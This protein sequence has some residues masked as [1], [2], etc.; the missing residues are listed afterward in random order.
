MPDW[1]NDPAVRI[2]RLLASADRRLRESFL[3]VVSY[4][5]DQQS[6]V[7]IESLLL[8]GQLELAIER[9]GAAFA[10]F[11][12]DYVGVMVTTAAN[13]A[14]LLGDA[15]GVLVSFDQ[16]HFR[17]VSA[18]QSNRLRLIREF[19]ATQRDAT[20][21]SLIDTISRGLGPRQQALAFRSSIGLTA[22][23]EAAVQNFRRMLVEGDKALFT[24]ALRDRRFDPTIRNALASGKPLTG[25]QVE[26]MVGRYRER[27]IKHRTEV[28]ARTES[29]RSVHQADQL[30]YQQAIDEGTLNPGDVEQFWNTANDER[31]RDTHGPMHGQ[32][33][34]M[35]V[36]FT[37]GDGDQL[38]FP[39][40]PSAPPDETI[41]CRCLVTRRFRAPE[42]V[43]VP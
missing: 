8:S 41:Q 30:M 12:D 27:Y 35:G 32:V 17:A 28:I 34:P 15:L 20:R 43:G 24:R 1:H 33:Q 9:A 16:T 23:Q 2:E 39:G 6:L 38:M 21:L 4:I 40:D 3:R 25:Q 31:V 36:P 13:T 10:R 37:T 22:R 7:A 5:R 18:M 11:A 14:G 29:L 26:Q 42:P 19:T